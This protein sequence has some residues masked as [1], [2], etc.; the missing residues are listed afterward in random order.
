MPTLGVCLRLTQIPF[1][2]RAQKIVYSESYAT[3]SIFDDHLA[4]MEAVMRRN[5]LHLD[6]YTDDQDREVER[7][8][9][10]GARRYPWR[11]RPGADFVVLEDPDRNL[12]CVVQ[13]SLSVGRIGRL[14]S[15]PPQCAFSRLSVPHTLN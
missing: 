8:V 11:Y 2:L 6:L 5:W 3:A 10:V 7:L 15:T 13:K 1:F 4:R 12:F 14:K 9:A